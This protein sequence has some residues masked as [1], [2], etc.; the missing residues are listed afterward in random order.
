VRSIGSVGL[1]IFTSQSQPPPLPPIFFPTPS[2]SLFTPTRVTSLVGVPPPLLHPSASCPYPPMSRTPCIASLHLYRYSSAPH[3]AYSGPVPLPIRPPV[4]NSA[5]SAVHP[6]FDVL[7]PARR[8][9]VSYM[10][11]HPRSAASL[12][13][14]QRLS[15]ALVSSVA[16]SARSSRSG[17]SGVW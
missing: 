5:W 6:S 4:L 1:G 3:L 2:T 17:Q 9:N 10:H 11:L 12:S 16:L 13:R 14:P 8:P 15:S 7:P